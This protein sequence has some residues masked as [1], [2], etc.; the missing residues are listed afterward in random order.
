MAS[1]GEASLANLRTEEAHRD[2]TVR[3]AGRHGNTGRTGRA[4]ALQR[5]ISA[6][7]RRT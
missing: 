3:S 1:S 6:F 2:G 4:S 5:E 7:P